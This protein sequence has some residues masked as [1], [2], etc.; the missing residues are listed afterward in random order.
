M[1]VCAREQLY[2]GALTSTLC[3]AGG[4]L[5]ACSDPA[6]CSAAATAVAMSLPPNCSHC[7][8]HF[9]P[10]H[11]NGYSSTAV[12]RPGPEVAG[13]AQKDLVARLQQCSHAVVT[14][15]NIDAVPTAVLPVL[16]TA[17]SEQG[18]FEHSGKQIDTTK[19]L[20]VGILQ[21]PATTLQQVRLKHLIGLRHV[22][23]CKV[24]V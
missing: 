8:H 11:G 21:V 23:S 19:A 2:F 12:E 17:L 6:S 24:L 10:R 4:V 9:L 13:Q 18:Q 20:F 5:L 7:L 16:I 22:M 3:Q 1:S 15:N 14:V